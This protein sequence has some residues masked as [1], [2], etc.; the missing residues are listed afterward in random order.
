MGGHGTQF[1]TPGEGRW[2]GNTASAAPPP[3]E[4]A[5]GRLWEPPLRDA[6]GPCVGAH[7]VRPPSLGI[8][9]LPGPFVGARFARPPLP[10]AEPMHY[11][12]AGLPPAA[13]RFGGG[14]KTAQGPGPL[15]GLALLCSVL[16]CSCGSL[17]SVYA[18]LHLLPPACSRL[19]LLVFVDPCFSRAGAGCGAG[20]VS[21][22]PLWASHHAGN[23]GSFGERVGL[24]SF[25]RGTSWYLAINLLI[26]LMSFA[27]AR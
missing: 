21:H 12:G 19:F 26:T 20:Q 8:R 1:T 14:T 9:T 5:F 17:T 7:T 3:L 24:T 15:R 27:A 23:A 13:F 6:S 10:F 25:E 16:S 11:A 22:S 2:G 18:C 4:K